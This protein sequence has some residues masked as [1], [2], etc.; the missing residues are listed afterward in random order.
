[1][2]NFISK[3]LFL[4]PGLGDI[5]GIQKSG[6]VAYLGLLNQKKI[7]DR[8][9]FVTYEN[10]KNIHISGLSDQYYKL[11][12]L[13]KLIITRSKLEIILR[14][15]TIKYPIS[16]ILVWHIHLLKL[17]PFLRL[18][19]APV[20][21]FLHG[22]EAWRTPSFL[23]KLGLKSVK[24]FLCNSQYTWDEFLRY[25]PD[26]QNK[27]HH[28]VHL[29][30][31]TPIIGPT[32]SPSTLPSALMISRLLHSE[33]YKGHREVIR[34]WP[35]VLSHIPEATLWIV[36]EGD[37]RSELERMVHET[38]LEHS[39]RFLGNVEEAEKQRLILQSRCLV[40]P[41]RGEGF[42]LV[43]LEAMRLGRPC[44]VSIWDAGKEV[45]NPPEAGLAVDPSDPMA[46][47]RAIVRLLTLDLEWYRWSQQARKRYEDYFTSTHFQQR[48]L[49]AIQNWIL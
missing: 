19:N 48:L 40:M 4:F 41:S 37:L 34:A 36:G 26:F 35:F 29:G 5:G 21:L 43:Y 18:H 13:S 49:S 31:E 38:G 16:M 42:G 1:M 22:I 45:I 44:L 6:M 12:N 9:I 15:L 28:I 17:I 2:R 46:L 20:I 11:Q 7:L 47:S 30:V 3:Y 24:S 33:N 8:S 14:I 10:K 27:P 39:I 25:N 23:I 32:P